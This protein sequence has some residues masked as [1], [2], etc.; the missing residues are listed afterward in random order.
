M[1]FLLLSRIDDLQ[2]CDQSSFVMLSDLMVLC[3][4]NR[5]TPFSDKFLMFIKAHPRWQSRFDA[6]T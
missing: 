1:P 2:V 6:G 5:N 4:V 3:F